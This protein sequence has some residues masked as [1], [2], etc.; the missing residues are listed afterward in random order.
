[1]ILGLKRKRSLLLAAAISNAALVFIAAGPASLAIYVV[2][3]V[4]PALALTEALWRS[5]SLTS[6]GATSLVAMTMIGWAMVAGYSKLYHV[7]PVSEM[8]QSVSEFVDHLDKTVAENGGD[9]EKTL[10]D[11]AE[12]EQ[13]KQSLVSELPSAIAV[14]GLLTI[15]ANLVLL[16]RINP[17]VTLVPVDQWKAPEWLVW[18][19]IVAGSALI[20]DWGP[21]GEVARNLF[22]FFMAIYALQGL[23]VMAFFFNHWRVGRFLRLAGYL[24]SALVMTPLLLSLGFFDLWF[25][26]RSK[27]RQS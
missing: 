16:V 19:T 21:A 6:A 11:P 3:C 10:G 4:V 9:P 23:S 18:P 2:F 8:K 20:F 15:W 22:K 14:I 13:W 27:F 17:L 24:L 5:R 12:I 1:M 26:F 7:H 25:D